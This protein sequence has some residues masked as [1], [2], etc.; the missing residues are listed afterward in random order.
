MSTRRRGPGAAERAHVDALAVLGLAATAT[1]QEVRAARRR[2]AKTA[3]PD[4]GGVD[5]HMRLINEAAD[6]VLAA[7]AARTGRRTP[8]DRD[9]STLRRDHPS[10]VVEA[11]PAETFEALRLVA[12]CLG[13]V[14]DDDPPYCLE[15]V[16]A[17]PPGIW[18]RLDLVPDA[19]ASTVS[20][21]ASGSPMPDL[22]SV[23][24][25]LVDELNRLDWSALLA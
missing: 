4:V 16:F 23:R 24:D 11:L 20:V 21:T 9:S 18:C 10:F 5:D 15:M 8:P 19:G 12:T 3:H 22:D 25:A 1:E 2:L 13:E 14:V 6:V 17:D 7:I